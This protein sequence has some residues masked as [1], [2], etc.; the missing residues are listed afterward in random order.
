MPTFSR[1]EL[2]TISCFCYSV[3]PVLT[4]EDGD[5]GVVAMTTRVQTTGFTFFH[6]SLATTPLLGSG[7][8]AFDP[9]T[10]DQIAVG[11]WTIGLSLQVTW[12]T[13]DPVVASLPVE[14]AAVAVV[15]G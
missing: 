9:P 4:I 1:S 14:D 6:P 12:A 15:A 5:G 7:A 13:Y 10:P 3:V 2:L 8:D 11:P